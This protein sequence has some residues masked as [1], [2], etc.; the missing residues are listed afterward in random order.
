M[1]ARAW[2][3]GLLRGN[4]ALRAYGRKAKKTAVVMDGGRSGTTG[5]EGYCSVS[6]ILILRFLKR[7]SVGPDS[8]TWTGQ[9]SLRPAG[10][11][12]GRKLGD[13]TVPSVISIPD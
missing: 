13:R 10:H 4:K 3:L 2:W 11:F 12:N 6:L 9:V 7:A 8:H 5:A 1:G